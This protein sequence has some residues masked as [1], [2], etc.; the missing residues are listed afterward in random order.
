MIKIYLLLKRVVIVGREQG[1][2]IVLI[3]IKKRIINKLHNKLIKPA[4]P[5]GSPLATKLLRGL[6][7]LEIG[8]SA[9][10]AFYLDTKN[11]DFT[12]SL[13]TIYKLDEKRLCGKA[14]PVDIVAP[15]DN[16]PVPDNSY[17]F[18]I[19]SHVLE[20][21]FDPIRTLLEWYRVIKNGGYIF[22]I[23]PHKE[24]TFDKD[25]PRT[26]LR[27]LIQRHE[28]GLIGDDT[29]EHYSVWITEDVV[30]LVKYLGWKTLVV[31]DVD[32]KVGN[33]FTVV[34]QKEA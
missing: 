15:G 19:S 12:D 34:I 22:M 21:F 14:M 9:H 29:H 4:K 33:G 30:E 8:G 25:R 20:H 31:Q 6:K 1:V 11:V 24:R 17:D 32:D 2:G 16:L 5:Q 3:R 13:D 26:T 10:N 23:I 7:G 28:N 27:E 18:V